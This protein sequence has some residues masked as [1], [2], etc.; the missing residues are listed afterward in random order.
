MP[1]KIVERFETLIKLTRNEL[2]DVQKLLLGKYDLSIQEYG[3][4]V[5]LTEDKDAWTNLIESTKDIEIED[6][7]IDVKLVNQII[8]KELIFKI[9]SREANKIKKILEGKVK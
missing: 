8:F 7:K 9:Q 2:I 4:Q 1:E 6:N 3:D 5:L